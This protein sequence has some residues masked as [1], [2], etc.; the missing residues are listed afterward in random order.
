MTARNHTLPGLLLA[1]SADSWGDERER[2]VMLEAYAYVFILTSY[3][4]WT[5]GAVIAWFIPAWVV[6]VLFLTFLL[7]SLE[8]QRYS[9]AR[10]VDANALA[11]T[12]SSLLRTALTGAYFC[13][14]ALSM[15]AAAAVQW[16]PDSSATLRGGLIGGV[17]GGA[18]AILYGWWHAKKKAARSEAAAPDEL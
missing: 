4:L 9:G 14:C 11:Y 3:L 7:P 15:W 6:V 17:C 13:A 16:I 8:W 5:V 12:G 18:A 2:A 1:R 10:G